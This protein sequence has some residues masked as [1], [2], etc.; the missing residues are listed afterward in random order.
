MAS[1]SSSS[2]DSDSS[3]E[4]RRR[5]EKK[6]AKKEK[7][8]KK[9]KKEKKERKEKKEKR[10]RPRVDAS[11]RSGAP[12]AVAAADRLD[13]DD[14]FAKAEEF[15]VWLHDARGL[16]LDEMSTD[17]A[18]AAFDDGFVAAYN[19]GALADH[20]YDGVPAAVRNRCK[21][22]RHAWA[23]NLSDQERWDLASTRD[24]IAVQTRRAD[25]TKIRQLPRAAAEPGAF[26]RPCRP[27]VKPRDAAAD[28][29]RAAGAAPPRP[30]G[31]P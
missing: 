1:S 25:P 8:K 16:F 23:F 5:K 27:A 26:A 3:D 20:F 29:A 31:P 18:R 15:R 6:K 14:Y 28:A 21:R 24:S 13:G 2:S 4:K 9:H 11:L 22:T 30:P 7:K 10:K 12:R 19:G 17:A